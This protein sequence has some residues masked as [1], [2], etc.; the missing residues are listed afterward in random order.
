MGP[1]PMG[2]DDIADA[3]M[4][5]RIAE[6]E[7]ARQWSLDDQQLRDRLREDLQQQKLFDEIVQELRRR[8]YIEIRGA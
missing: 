8:T 2:G 5:I 7:P 6:R 4:V 1:I 3:F